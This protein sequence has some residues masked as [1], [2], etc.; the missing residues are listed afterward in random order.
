MLEYLCLLDS[1]ATRIMDCGIVAWSP[2]H[3]SLYRIHFKSSLAFTSSKLVLASRSSCLVATSGLEVPWHCFKNFCGQLQPSMHDC[4][5]STDCYRFLLGSLAASIKQRNP[6][7]EIA[8]LF[9]PSGTTSSTYLLPF[10]PLDNNASPW[11]QRR[12]GA[13]MDADQTPIHRALLDAAQDIEGDYEH[14]LNR[15]VPCQVGGPAFSH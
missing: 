1:S 10:L 6:A 7:I 12:L 13:T 14:P 8:L 3:E 4:I 11:W 5:V 15:R 9:Y 2:R